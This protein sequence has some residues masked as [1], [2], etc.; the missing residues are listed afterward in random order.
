MSALLPTNGIE[1]R[2]WMGIELFGSKKRYWGGLREL[3][4]LANENEGRDVE[5]VETKERERMNRGW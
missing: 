2:V 4:V 5:D 3:D 1:T